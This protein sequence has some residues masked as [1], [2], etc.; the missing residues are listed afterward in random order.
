MAYAVAAG[1]VAGLMAMI[2]Y[3]VFQ[4]DGL[5]HMLAGLQFPTA[6]AAIAFCWF[7]VRLGTWLF[8]GLTG[9]MMLL[10]SRRWRRMKE[11]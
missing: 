11:A 6:E 2:C 8:G 3:P 4:S 9:G 10:L 7:P 1:Y 5:Q